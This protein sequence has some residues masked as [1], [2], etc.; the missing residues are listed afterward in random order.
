MPG[1]KLTPVS[2]DPREVARR[3]LQWPISVLETAGILCLVIS[4]TILV[5]SGHSTPSPDEVSKDESLAYESGRLI[6]VL[7]IPVLGLFWSGLVLAGARKMRKLRN[8]QFVV[9]TAIVAIIPVTVCFWLGTPG[10][11]WALVRLRQPTVRDAF[12]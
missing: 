1:E 7:V 12:E 3:A 9:W 10:G 8:Y 2:S 6:V 4:I 11:I 5:T